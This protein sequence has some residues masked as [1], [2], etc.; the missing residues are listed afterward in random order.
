MVARL[1]IFHAQALREARELSFDSRV[2]IANEAAAEAKSNA[3]QLTGAY[4]GG[5]GVEVEG[6]RVFIVDTDEDALHKEYGTSDTPAHAALTD[7]ARSRGK[8]SGWR[9]RGRRR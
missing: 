6:R 5:I 8:Y 7:A 4:R 2:D 3:P 1:R 9:P